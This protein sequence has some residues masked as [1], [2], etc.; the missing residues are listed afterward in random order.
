MTT[1]RI[2]PSALDLF[3]KYHSRYPRIEMSRIGF[4]GGLTEAGRFYLQPSR[5]G[6]PLGQVIRMGYPLI[7]VNHAG[8]DPTAEFKSESGIDPAVQMENAYWQLIQEQFL[9]GRRYSV[10]LYEPSVPSWYNV[11]IRM[12]PTFPVQF[13]VWPAIKR[14]MVINPRYQEPRAYLHWSAFVPE[15]TPE[16]DAIAAANDL[17][18]IANRKGVK[19]AA[20]EIDKLK[21]VVFDK[22]KLADA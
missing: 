19:P 7:D 5:A 10:R 1:D 18:V 21:A 9:N 2:P 6:N 11:P 17:A 12:Q 20:P 4:R 13:T 3:R 16:H 8:L 22:L 14:G 15:G